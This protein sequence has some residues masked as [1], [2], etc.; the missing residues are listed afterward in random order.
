MLAA[1]VG[2]SHK[3][4]YTTLE[5]LALQ[6]KHYIL[7][8][9]YCG[10]RRRSREFMTSYW[11]KQNSVYTLRLRQNGHQFPDDIFK[12]ISWMTICKFR[13]R[14]CWI[15]FLIVQLTIFQHCRQPLSEPMMDGLLTH[16]RVTRPQ[17]DKR[18]MPQFT[19]HIDGLVQD[20]SFSIANALGILQ[21]CTKLSRYG[22]C[23]RRLTPNQPF[24]WKEGL[25]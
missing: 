19:E 4:I 12:C 16:T 21:C 3:Y 10:M 8:T 7:I 6:K 15:L 24:I 11:T 1:I 18:M 5:T 25:V 22:S 17:V 9:H 20:S 13:L 2:N 14:F 23:C